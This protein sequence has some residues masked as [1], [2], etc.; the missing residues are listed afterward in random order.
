MCICLLVYVDA[1]I[2]FTYVCVYTY[3][4]KVLLF[5]LLSLLPAVLRL[6]QRADPV[7]RG[8]GSELPLAEP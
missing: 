7:V 1:F 5:L 3:L 2:M 8:Q 4:P 6:I